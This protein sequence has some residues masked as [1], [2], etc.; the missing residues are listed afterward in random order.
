MSIEYV[1]TTLHKK[2]V[3]TGLEAVIGYAIMFGVYVLVDLLFVFVFGASL[4]VR[5]YTC[6]FMME[7]VLLK[8]IMGCMNSPL[9][10]GLTM[11]L[12]IIFFPLIHILALAL[13][14]KVADN[15]YIK[16][17]LDETCERVNR[18]VEENKSRAA[19]R[20][21]QHLLNLYKSC[22]GEFSR[23]REDLRRVL[24]KKLHTEM[25]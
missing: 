1:L 19:K 11:I 24:N 20:E 7:V 9:L 25:K 14:F 16:S 18:L 13:K 15:E 8:R 12:A 23:E 3:Y 5:I 2:R 4:D 22:F 6:I 17:D 10:M 21:A